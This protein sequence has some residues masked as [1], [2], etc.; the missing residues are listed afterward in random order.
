MSLKTYGSII[1]ELGPVDPVSYP[2]LAL[3]YTIVTAVYVA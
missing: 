2:Y 3:T 1:I